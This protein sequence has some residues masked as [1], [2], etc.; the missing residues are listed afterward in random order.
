MRLRN[1]RQQDVRERCY[2]CF[3]PRSACFCAQ[4]PDIDN[5]T[6]ILILQHVKERFHAF[7]TARIVKAALR[8]SQ[9]LV[10]QTPLLAQRKLPLCESTGVLYPGDEATLLND[11]APSQRPRQLVI[12]DGTWHHA[13]TFMKQIPV[14][15]TLPRFCLQPETPST[16][17]IRREPTESALSTLE[18]T[19]AALRFLEPDT[20]GLDDLIAAFDTMIDTQLQHPRQSVRVRQRR[21]SWRPAANVPGSILNDHDRLV[22]VYGEASFGG[23]QAGAADRQPVYW[24]AQRLATGD[25]F[26]CPVQATDLNTDFLSHMELTADQFAGAGVAAFCEKWQAFTR[27]NDILVA[28]NESTL[29]LLSTIGLSPA[30]GISLKSVNLTPQAKTL[31]DVLKAVCVT[32]SAV[33]CSGRPGK[34]LA[35]AVALTEY[36]RQPG[37]AR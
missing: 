33:R 18:A 17:R 11:L 36:L 9:L 21:E 13:Q 24:V 27:P 16:Y 1:E 8:N 25:V 5:R 22:V 3:R 4:I 28:Y 35:N 7:N 12:L 32:P 14:L 10:D 20:A 29:R 6:E 23:Q 26:E 30:R 34:R 2:T 37:R 15:Q 19:V 31:E